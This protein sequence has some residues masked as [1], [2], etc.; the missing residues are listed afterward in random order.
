MNDETKDK[1]DNLWDEL[2]ERE[3]QL[4]ELNHEIAELRD[5]ISEILDREV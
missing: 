3:C 1:I 2:T 4:E 5:E